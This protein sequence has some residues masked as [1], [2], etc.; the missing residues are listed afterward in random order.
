[1]YSSG[2]PES[3][4]D[5]NGFITI[6]AARLTAGVKPAARWRRRR[7]EEYPMNI[8]ESRNQYGSDAARAR[9]HLDADPFAGSSCGWLGD[10]ETARR[11]RTC[12]HGLGYRRRSMGC[13]SGPHGSA[14]RGLDSRGFI[15]YTNL[16]SRKAQVGD[17]GQSP[18]CLGFSLAETGT[19]GADPEGK[20]E[21]SAQMIWPTPY[22]RT[23]PRGS[24]LGA[25]ASPQSRNL[26]PAGPRLGKRIT[27]QKS[28][29]GVA[30]GPIERP[31]RFG[32]AI[33]WVPARSN[34]GRAAYPGCTI[35]F[36]YMR[37]Q[38]DTW[39][40]VRLAPVG[41]G[42]K[43]I[44]VRLAYSV[45]RD[46]RISFNSGA[47]GDG[48]SSRSRDMSYQANLA[49][50]LGLWPHPLIL[51]GSSHHQKNSDVIGSLTAAVI[52]RWLRV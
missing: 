42:W 4:L 35:R 31:R 5:S 14:L 16:H 15:F 39:S 30:D 43:R 28:K 18:G 24:Q 8:A 1:M 34:S 9:T 47:N 23:R 25:W 11:A 17:G 12:R 46:G 45:G 10:A 48:L 50:S 19:P 32:E 6:S 21:P 41:P 51:N 22:F 37:Q 2:R 52:C 29:R 26:W 33:A 13:A 3:F 7:I 44:L 20:V 49:V 27:A 38:D 40:I 36:C